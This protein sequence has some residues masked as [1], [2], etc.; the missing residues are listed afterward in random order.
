MLTEFI[1]WVLRTVTTAAEAE[2]NDDTAL[3]EQL[4]EAE[5]RRE[6]A[7]ISD[8]EF[9]EIEADLLRR[10]REIREQRGESGPLGLGAQPVDL[11]GDARVQIEASVTGDFHERAEAPH[12]TVIEST[13][14]HE[15]RV[16]ILDLKP[17]QASPE[18][19]RRKR[20][21]TRARTPSKG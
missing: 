5:M 16:S 19:A 2:M 21:A 9:A 13:P 12:T 1:G 20:R 18:L 8:E 11:S 3:R 15:E 10:I 7:E 17:D 6:T 14:D 4:L